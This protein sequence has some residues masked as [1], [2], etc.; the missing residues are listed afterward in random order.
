MAKADVTVRSRQGWL[1][2]IARA[3]IALGIVA[4]LASPILAATG[5]LVCTTNAPTATGGEPAGHSRRQF[6]A[7]GLHW[8]F[9]TNLNKA[10][11]I[12][13]TSSDG[14]TWSGETVFRTSELGAGTA[15]GDKFSVWFDGTHVHYAYSIG[16]DNYAM[17]YRM[18]TPNSDGSITWAAAEQTAQA[19]VANHRYYVPTIATDTSGY[20]WIG[21]YYFDSG[22]VTQDAIAVKSS[23]NDGTWTTA[24]GFPYTLEAGAG[25]CVPVEPVPLTSGKMYMVFTAT[26]SGNYPLQGREWNGSAWEAEQSIGTMPYTDDFS[27]VT[28]GDKVCLVYVDA[29]QN[30]RYTE[31]GTGGTWGG[32]VTIAAA[33]GS[34]S[35]FPA[36]C[37]TRAA[38]E[39]LMVLWTVPGSDLIYY[40]TRSGGTWSTAGTWIDESVDTL[41]AAAGN[42]GAPS[43]SFTDY[44][45]YTSLIYVTKAGTPHDVK[46]SV[47]GAP[48][49]A[50]EPGSVLL[51]TVLPIALAAVIMVG[52]MMTT[53]NPVASLTGAVIGLITFKVALILLGIL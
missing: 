40:S 36:L 41:A 30:L 23:T 34:N 20:P 5:N 6:C 28:I 49:P 25:H 47:L 48:M 18:G 43:T 26:V 44:D 9:T 37:V 29:S 39:R 32:L 22:A 53:G 35:V 19:A 38:S 13:R 16:I 4:I 7:E 11:Y 51:S 8:V 45:G 10:S 33:L 31:R 1:K 15:N 42:K 12:W 21:Y 17:F 24:G 14:V 2:V 52:M 3:A 27:A 46:F 50:P